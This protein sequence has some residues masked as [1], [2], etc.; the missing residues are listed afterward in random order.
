M[1]LRPTNCKTEADQS[2]RDSVR[3]P[4]E[5][6]IVVATPD[7]YSKCPSGKVLPTVTLLIFVNSVS[8]LPDLC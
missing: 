6:G 3:L 7:H 2:G 4:D 8:I 1:S 5:T